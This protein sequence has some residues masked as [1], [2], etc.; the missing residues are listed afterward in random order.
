MTVA[1][2]MLDMFGLLGRAAYRPAV[3][4]SLSPDLLCVEGIF[5]ARAQ[6]AVKRW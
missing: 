3:Q 2:F 5:G 1:L 4:D 6:P